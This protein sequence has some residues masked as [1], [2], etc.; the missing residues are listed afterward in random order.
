L[1]ALAYPQP[2]IGCCKSIKNAMPYSA[3]PFFQCRDVTVAF[4]ERREG[5]EKEE[6]HKKRITTLEREISLRQVASLIKPNL[7]D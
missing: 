3:N 2:K 5:D 1:I 6:T 7:G 4:A